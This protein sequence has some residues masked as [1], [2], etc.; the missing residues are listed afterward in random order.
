[1]ELHEIRHQKAKIIIGKNGLSSGTIKAIQDFVKREGIVKV[2][3]LKSA[4][5]AEYSKNELV[6][7]LINKTDLHVI[8]TRGFSVI[9]TKL[10]L[11]K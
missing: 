4:L 11:N 9:L 8:E 1:M 5:T 2:K 7:D 10:S 6:K 3:I